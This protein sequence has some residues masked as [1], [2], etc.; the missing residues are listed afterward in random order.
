MTVLEVYTVQ[1]EKRIRGERK[2]RERERERDCRPAVE[3]LTLFTNER[4]GEQI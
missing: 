1:Y 4:D 2:E 3:C